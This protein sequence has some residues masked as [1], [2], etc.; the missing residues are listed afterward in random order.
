LLLNN[1]YVNFIILFLLS[2]CSVSTYHPDSK[3]EQP[4][5]KVESEIVERNSLQLLTYSKTTLG[6]RASIITGILKSKNNCLYIEVGNKDIALIFPNNYFIENGSIYGEAKAIE[7]GQ[8]VYFAGHGI[9]INEKV[10]SERR[11]SV[12]QCLATISS[13]WLIGQ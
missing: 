9:N 2:G 7:L 11:I 12:N 5:N 4:M 8:I 1:I 3:V 13:A 6:S 10:V